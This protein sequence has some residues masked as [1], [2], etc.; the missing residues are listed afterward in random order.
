MRH[1]V[2]RGAPGEPGAGGGGEAA[3]GLARQLAVVLDELLDE[4]H[5]GVDDRGGAHGQQQRGDGELALGVDVVDGVVVEM[6]VVQ[7]QLIFGDRH[8]NHRIGCVFSSTNLF[9]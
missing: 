6:G 4:R 8:A 5:A 9:K 1:E 7:Y 3:D 2:G